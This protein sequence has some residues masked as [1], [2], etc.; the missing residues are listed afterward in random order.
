M[1]VVVWDGKTLAADRQGTSGE[2]KMP[3]SKIKKLPSGEIVAWVGDQLS[4]LKLIHWYESG[5]NADDFPLDI[6]N[7][8]RHAVLVVAGFHG[9]VF[10]AVDAYPL[11]CEGPYMAWGSGDGYALGALA[12]GADAVRAVE[13][14]SQLSILCG[15]GV[16]AFTVEA[17]A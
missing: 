7:E 17:A 5:A 11:P 6:S 12:M 16:D 9:A 13:I 14:A 2:L 1:S 3:M 10:Y 4:G 15:F 8:E